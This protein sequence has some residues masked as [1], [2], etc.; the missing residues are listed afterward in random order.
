MKEKG[1]FKTYLFLL[2]RGVEKSWWNGLYQ[3]FW[4]FQLLHMAVCEK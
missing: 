1:K 3:L 4:L 2:H